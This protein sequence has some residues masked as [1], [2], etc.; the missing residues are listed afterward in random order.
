M[1]QTALREY[2]RCVSEIQL[3]LTGKAQSPTIGVGLKRRDPVLCWSDKKKLWDG[4]MSFIS[5]TP[6]QFFVRSGEVK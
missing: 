2:E 6:N 1:R 5:E 4:P 3:K